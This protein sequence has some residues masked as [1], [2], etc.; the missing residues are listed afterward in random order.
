[1]EYDLLQ[2]RTEVNVMAMRE[3]MSYEE[4][5]RRGEAIYNAQIRHLI[6]PEDEGKYVVVD[7]LTGDYE[8]HENSGTAGFRLHERRPDAVIHTMR[9]HKTDVIRIRG[10]IRPMQ[11]EKTAE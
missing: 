1:M 4:Q 5:K 8:I 6:G 3:R 9:R 7:V 11:R 10:L 2:K